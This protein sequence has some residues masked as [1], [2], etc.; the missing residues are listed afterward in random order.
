MNTNGISQDRVIDITTISVM[1]TIKV[2]CS[3]RSESK[4]SGC[5]ARFHVVIQRS[6]T[7]LAFDIAN[8]T[9]WPL[10][11]PSNGNEV[12]EGLRRGFCSLEVAF[13]G[14]TGQKS[15]MWPQPDHKV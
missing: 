14:S 2:C 7:L 15:V 1:Y 5:G 10:R 13:I 4:G 3:L 8:F 11:L 9:L 12:F 6:K